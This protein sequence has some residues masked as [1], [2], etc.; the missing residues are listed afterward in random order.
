[1]WQWLRSRITRNKSGQPADWQSIAA[2]RACWSKACN[3]A[4]G[5]ACKILSLAGEEVTPWNIARFVKSLPQL[6]TESN[7]RTWQD[8]SYCFSCFGKACAENPK[9]TDCWRAIVDAGEFLVTFLAA[10]PVLREMV[11]E[12]LVAVLEPL[13]V[14]EFGERE[15]RRLSPSA[16]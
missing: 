11:V 8:N 6:R 10:R 3:D 2:W 12:A 4:C 9:G 5:H 15:R 16:N 7:E 1:M 14:V 13:D